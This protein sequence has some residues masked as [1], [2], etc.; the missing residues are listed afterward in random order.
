MVLASDGLVFK[1]A[2]SSE[3]DRVACTFFVIAL[4][5]GTIV[6]M[7]WT[8]MRRLLYKVSEESIEIEQF[9][10]EQLLSEG[11]WRITTAMPT[12]RATHFHSL[13]LRFT[14][15]AN[16]TTSYQPQV[17]MQTTGA[18]VPSPET[19]S[20]PRIRVRTDQIGE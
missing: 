17:M 6:L 19:M 3:A 9:E 4:I 7:L 13:T 10:V 16:S 14:T 20:L 5:C 1:S 18:G 11:K 15:G 8:L 12:N 2:M